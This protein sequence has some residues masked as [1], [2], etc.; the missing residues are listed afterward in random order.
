MAGNSAD[1]TQFDRSE[2]TAKK[3]REPNEKHSEAHPARR[4]IKPI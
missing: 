2:R 4:A 3:S 1:R